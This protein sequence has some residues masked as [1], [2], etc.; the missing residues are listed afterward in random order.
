MVIF[1][2]IKRFLG[3]LGFLWC[4]HCGR[5]LEYQYTHGYFDEKV[6]ACSH[7]DNL[8]RFDISYEDIVNET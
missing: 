2:Y 3:W 4:P 6:Y 5:R 7:C 1:T 8:D